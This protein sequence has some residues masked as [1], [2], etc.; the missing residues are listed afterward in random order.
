MLTSEIKEGNKISVIVNKLEFD[1]EIQIIGDEYILAQL[2]TVDGKIVDF[3]SEMK[4]DMVY[5]DDN[6]NLY[7]WENISVSPVKLRDGNKYHKIDIPETEGKRYNRRGSYRLFIGKEM[8]IELKEGA[9]RTRKK[10]LIRDISATGFAFIINE[11]YNVGL[12]VT[13]FFDMGNGKRIDIAAK[14]VRKQYMERTESNLYGCRFL[15]PSD[16][17]RR[18]VNR[19]QQRIMQEKLQ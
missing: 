19:E 10:T 18:M 8:G 11:D 1:S 9:M 16:E 15:V 7:L 2:I 17:I 14:I 13:L 5:F 6:N 4:V 3:P 12:R